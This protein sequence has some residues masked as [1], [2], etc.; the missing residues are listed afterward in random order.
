MDIINP[1]D[2]ESNNKPALDAVLKSLRAAVN[3]NNDPLADA[4]IPLAEGLQFG[5]LANLSP[6]LPLFFSYGGEPLT[7][8][9]HFPLEPLFDNFI[10]ADI[11][12]LCSRQI[13]K[14][15]Q[16]AAGTI[17]ECN[18]NSDWDVLFVAPFYEMIRRV[19]TDYFV[20]LERES[21]IRAL[22][23]G[24]GCIKQ[25]LE[26][27]YPNRSRVRF[28]YAHKSADRARGIHARALRLDERQLMDRDIIP[29]LKATMLSSKYKEYVFSA[30]TPLTN[31]N[32]TSTMFREQ[33]TRS[34]WMIPCRSCGKENIA[35]LECDLVQMIGPPDDNISPAHPGLICAKSECNYPL[36][37]Q[38]GRFI[39][40]NP[41][42][43]HEALGLHIP[44]IVLPHHCCNADRWAALWRTMNDPMIPDFQKYNEYLGVPYDDGL[45]L[46]SEN[47]MQRAATLDENRLEIA[48]AKLAKYNGRV[49]VGVDWGGGGMSGESLTKLAVVGLTSTG[50]IEVPFGLTIMGSASRTDEAKTIFYVLQKVQPLIFAHDTNGIGDATEELLLNLG[51]PQKRVWPMSYVGETGGTMMTLKPP[52]MGRPKSYW[53]VDKARS[54]LHIAETIKTGNMFF[55][56]M[57]KR[58]NARDLLLDFTHMVIEE[59]VY[60]D[61]MRSNAV[62][63]NREEGQSDDFVHAVNFARLALCQNFK[64]WP[65]LSQK[66]TL[67]TLQELSTYIPKMRRC[68]DPESI[69]ALRFTETGLPA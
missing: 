31:S 66:L 47:D 53:T 1:S 14:T 43:R 32:P 2:E 50:K 56:Q 13:G 11:L 24:T 44:M 7:L 4:L 29:V 67:R 40:F 36:F 54:L 65:K 5:P 22:L 35:A 8:N 61:S 64:A 6:L 19:S 15:L 57:T 17:L 30:A 21:P 58:Y 60:V 49:A 38:D 27:T 41:Q 46:L 34:H 9:N 59:K 33:T 12:L 18:L 48:C 42:F 28:T 51:F 23:T 63:V 26:R 69:D 37:P 3:R 62:L 68:L 25:V 52:S 10:P 20:Q 55:F 16:M 39:H 45:V